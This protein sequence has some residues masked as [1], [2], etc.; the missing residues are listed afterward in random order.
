MRENHE[1]PLRISVLAR[2]APT[3]LKKERRRH[4]TSQR[5]FP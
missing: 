1:L 2:S 4:G 5:L 3:H